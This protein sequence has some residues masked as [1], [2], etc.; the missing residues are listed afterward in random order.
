MNR[1]PLKLRLAAAA[2]VTLT[3]GTIGAA[4]AAPAIG[5]AH[6]VETHAVVSSHDHATAV[7]WIYRHHR[8]VWVPDHRYHR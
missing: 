7:R 8:R 2:V 3:L 1:L 6:G 5:T 4:S